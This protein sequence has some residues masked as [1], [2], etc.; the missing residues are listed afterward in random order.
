MTDSPE[1]SV[2]VTKLTASRQNG[3]AN[4]RDRH[5][6]MEGFEDGSMAWDE[7]WNDHE[8]IA[9]QAL[10]P[11]GR[12]R[13]KYGGSY[14]FARCYQDV[15]LNKGARLRVVDRQGLTLIVEPWQ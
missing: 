2:F 8:A 3:V 12:G 14:W 5:S 6:K 11:G 9:V 13:V 15:V 7:V 1:D 10:C 4:D